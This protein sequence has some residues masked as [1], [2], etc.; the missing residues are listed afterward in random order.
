MS[1][2]P[3]IIVPARLASMRFP[4]KLL[5]QV[6]G[7]P[8]ILWTAERIQSVAPEF[9]LYFA[10]DDDAL[11]RCLNEAGFNTVRTRPEHPSGTDRLAEANATVGAAAVI[12]V[13]GDEPLVTG[14]QIRALAAGLEGE[15]A[16]ATLAVPF[17]R[18]QDF[19]NPNQVKVVC[20]RAGYAMYF[21]R[22]PMP[23]ARD[24]AGQVDASWLAQNHC[25]RHL[26]LY[27]YKADFLSAFSSLE[28]GFLEQI[29]KL[30]QLRAMEHGYRI[31][32][33]ITDQATIG[34]DTPEDIGVF[35]AR[36]K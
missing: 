9:P 18:P 31:H 23:F 27:A 17:Q 24:T 12:N 10:V 30:E 16:I 4:Q 26:G 2:T 34:I 11:E 33:G 35:E 8:I 7:K 36:L 6:Q 32:V 5:Y 15:A 3:S 28:P 1:K 22:S 20:D 21:S 13:Q 19:A 14:E 25:Y 29:E